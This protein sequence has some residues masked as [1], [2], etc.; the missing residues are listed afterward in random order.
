MRQFSLDRAGCMIGNPAR[1]FLSLQLTSI[2]S[3][4]FSIAKPRQNAT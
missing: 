3:G 1:G 4:T 2:F